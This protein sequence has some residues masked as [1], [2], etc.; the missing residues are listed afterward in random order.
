MNGPDLSQSLYRRGIAALA[1]L[2]A[3]L[4]LVAVPL[5]DGRLD[6]SKGLVLLGS[7]G[8]L[9]ALS[10]LVLSAVRQDIRREPGGVTPWRRIAWQMIRDVLAV[11]GG[12]QL[13]AL[14]L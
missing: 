13:L 3:S 5:L 11:F 7:L 2:G 8:A 10:V 12:I 4:I 6:T 1:V 14:L 9:F